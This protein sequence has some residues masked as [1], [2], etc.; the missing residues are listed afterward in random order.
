MVSN[1]SLPR[2]IS[3][4]LLSRVGDD[5]DASN[6]TSNRFSVMASTSSSMSKNDGFLIMD[7]LRSAFSSKALGG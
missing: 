4:K 3:K 5:G 6:S 7:L 2:S 1:E